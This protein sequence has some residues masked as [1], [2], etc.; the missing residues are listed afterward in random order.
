MTFQTIALATG[1]LALLWVV[2]AH[3]LRRLAG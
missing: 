1:A 3:A 2:P